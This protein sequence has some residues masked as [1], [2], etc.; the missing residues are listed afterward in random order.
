ML[1]DSGLDPSQPREPLFSSIIAEDEPD[2]SSKDRIPVGFACYYYTYSTWQG[3]TLYMMALYVRDSHRKKGVGKLLIAELARHA[4]EIGCKRL[5]FHANK[6]S[7][8]TKYYQ[9]LGAIDLTALEEWHL[10]KFQL[11]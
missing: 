5:E 6:N 2:D 11:E 1:R 3:R 8:A 4:K 7:Q 10:F 9:N